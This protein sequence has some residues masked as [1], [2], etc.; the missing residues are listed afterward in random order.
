MASS[1]VQIRVDDKLKEDVTAVYEQLGLDL[2]TA[3]RMFFKRSVAEQG[4][5]FSVRLNDESKINSSKNKISSNIMTAM[6]S[7]ANSA[8]ENGISDMSLD[9]INAEI[10]SARK[11]L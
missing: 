5:P 7:M 4:I 3:V 2:S 10:S 1:L 6:Q 8:A 9:E 11:E